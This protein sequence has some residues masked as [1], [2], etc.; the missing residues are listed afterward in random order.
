MLDSVVL[1]R[2]VLSVNATETSV[3]QCQCPIGYEGLSCERCQNGYTRATPNGNELVQC[4]LCQCNGHSDQCDADTGECFDC[5]DNTTG[6]ACDQCSLGYYGNATVANGCQRCPCLSIG[7]SVDTSCSLSSDGLPTCESCA[8]GYTGRFCNACADGFFVAPG[9]GCQPCACSDKGTGC[10]PVTGICSCI[11]G[12]TG[13][14]CEECSPGSFDY[15]S[16]CLSCFCY[17]HASDCRSASG[18][19]A[20]TVSSDFEDGMPNGWLAID[21]LGAPTAASAQFFAV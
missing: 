5:K 14:T 7:S 6:L 18:F 16:G 15:S 4:V 2:A 11:E 21:A 19:E 10:D 13:P 8:K 20:T 1:R 12:F 9:G 3:E 17:G